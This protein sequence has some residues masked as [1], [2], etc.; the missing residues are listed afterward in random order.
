[1]ANK[2]DRGKTRLKISIHTPENN[3]D[4]IEQMNEMDKN[5]HNSTKLDKVNKC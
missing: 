4:K 3:S 1:M 5:G 2:N